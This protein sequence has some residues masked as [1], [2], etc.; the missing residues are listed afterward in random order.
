MAGGFLEQSK[1]SED[2]ASQRDFF[3]KREIARRILDFRFLILD[4]RTPVKLSL[5]NTRPLVRQ[6]IVR[7]A[8]WLGN[9]LSFR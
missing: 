4:W 9:D 8:R 3:R 7:P 6:R 1:L 5:S 2:L